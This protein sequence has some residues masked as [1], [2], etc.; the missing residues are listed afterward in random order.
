MAGQESTTAIKQLYKDRIKIFSQ[1]LDKIKQAISRITLI[2][3][4]TFVTGVLAV[5]YFAKHNQNYIIYSILIFVVIFIFLVKRHEKFLKKKRFKELLIRINKEELNYLDGKISAFDGGQEFLIKQDMHTADLDVFG[6]ESLFQKINRTAT[7]S[8]KHRL[9]LWF[10]F[11][12][13]RNEDILAK[14]KAVKELA[15]EVDFR[16]NFRAKALTEQEQRGDYVKMIRWMKEDNYFSNRLIFKILTYA[17]PILNIGATLI[18]S[19]GYF[20]YQVPVFF[21][22]LTL[23]FLGGY[24][25]TINRRHK[26]ISRRTKLLLKYV[27]LLK[28]MENREF[29]SILLKNL[30]QEMSVGKLKAHER[31]GNLVKILQALDQRLNMLMGVILNVYFFWDIRQLIRIENWKR[32]NAE[33]M[34]IWF[35]NIGIMDAYCSLATLSFNEPHWIFPKLSKDK[36][37]KGTGLRHPLMPTS[38]CVPNDIEIY[39]KPHFKII[40]GANM[41]GKST[42]LRTVGA[43]LLL[44]MMGSVVHAK[45]Y[46]FTP[47]KIAT[48]L[49]T[50]DS[51]MKNESY[52]YAELKR[53]QT[54]IHQL[55]KKE[56]V[57]VFLDEILKGT[58]SKDKELGSIALLEQLINL[59][60]YGIIATHD[61]NL[62]KVSMRFSEHTENLR[63]EAE[64]EQDKLFFDYQIKSGIAQNLNATFLMKRMGITI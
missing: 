37:L 41:A 16:Q 30:Q 47:A 23:V 4:I 32:K 46:E 28:L 36:L 11:P 1:E 53:L 3:F 40:T 22:L 26:I 12:N 31:I 59:E 38:S 10:R 51:L 64:I 27:D 57:I 55:E 34:I 62:A 60:A 14:Q 61:L 56:N 7:L 49:K 58:N 25:K 43:N 19:L 6:N 29:D 17:V 5:W 13:Q 45:E 15:A 18:Y 35:N 9:A 44:A 50:T 20:P 2:R 54:I 24:Q 42:Y 48:S 63:F 52:F 39:K 8:G 21:I 33:E